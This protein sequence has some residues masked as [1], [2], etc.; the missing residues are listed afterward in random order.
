MS[1]YSLT[2][3]FFAV[4]AFGN[5]QF[6]KASLSL[7]SLGS[8]ATA[9]EESRAARKRVASEYRMRGEKRAAAV[10]FLLLPQYGHQFVTGRKMDYYGPIHLP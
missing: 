7:F 2:F 3:S 4:R 10:P 9:R 6:D 8:L 5:S 1:T